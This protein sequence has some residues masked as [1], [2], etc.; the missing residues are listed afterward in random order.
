[1]RLRKESEQHR[2]LN[3]PSPHLL[4]GVLLLRDSAFPDQLFERYA[5]AMG[6]KTELVRHLCVSSVG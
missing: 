1:M 4:E 5:C 6:D 2:V 3:T